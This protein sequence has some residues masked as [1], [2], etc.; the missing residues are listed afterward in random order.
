MALN[1]F[2]NYKF[3]A[4]ATSILKIFMLLLVFDSAD[5]QM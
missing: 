4:H 2:D 5:R 3:I 1:A